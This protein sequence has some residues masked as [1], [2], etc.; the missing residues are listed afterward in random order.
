MLTDD[1]RAEIDRRITERILMFHQALVDRGQIEDIASDIG[2]NVN[3]QSFDCIPLEH[4]RWCAGQGDPIPRSD[5]P[6]L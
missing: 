1:D 4:R 5:D 3:H 6:V 2:P